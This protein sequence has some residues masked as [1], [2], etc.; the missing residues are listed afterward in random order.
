[1]FSGVLEMDAPMFLGTS[2]P[3]WQEGLRDKGI[4]RKLYLHRE[5]PKLKIVPATLKYVEIQQLTST[6]HFVI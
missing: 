6:F 3:S 1:M 5:R 4:P 2:E